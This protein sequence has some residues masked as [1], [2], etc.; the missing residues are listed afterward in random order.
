VEL[1]TVWTWLGMRKRT[2]RGES[3]SGLAFDRLVDP[4]ASA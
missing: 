3:A 4:P 1:Q 2:G